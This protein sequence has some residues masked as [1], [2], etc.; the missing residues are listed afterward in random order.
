MHSSPGSVTEDTG[1]VSVAQRVGCPPPCPCAAGAAGEGLPFESHLLQFQSF[2][3]LVD[4]TF[5]ESAFRD[6]GAEQSW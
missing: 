3:E 6:K 5:W 4:G 1:W 2:K